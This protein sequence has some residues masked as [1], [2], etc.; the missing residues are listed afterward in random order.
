MILLEKKNKPETVNLVNTKDS[1]GFQTKSKSSSTYYDKRHINIC[2]VP[3]M[4]YLTHNYDGVWTPTQEAIKAVMNGTLYL[5]KEGQ[6]YDMADLNKQS[7]RLDF[8]E[9]EMDNFIFREIGSGRIFVV[10]GAKD[11]WNAFMFTDGMD[12]VER[13]DLNID[14]TGNLQTGFTGTKSM[15]CALSEK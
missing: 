8:K 15:R 13:K 2:Q 3:Q 7:H 12:F 5:K 10:Q 6:T 4:P 1:F 14:M 9:Q 11:E